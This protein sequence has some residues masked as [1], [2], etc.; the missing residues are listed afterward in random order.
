M[1][2]Y[3]GATSLPTLQCLVPFDDWIS[4]FNES[5]LAFVSDSVKPRRHVD[6]LVS[7]EW[8]EDVWPRGFSRMARE[9]MYC[10]WAF[11]AVRSVIY[12]YALNYDD[13]P[14]VRIACIVCCVN[15]N[16]NMWCIRL[17]KLPQQ[18]L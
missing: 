16:I 2:V 1:G 18:T 8:I 3:A 17:Q 10:Q 14:S 12:G 15:G 9:R 7:Y 11:A 5:M 6:F 13:L 4:R